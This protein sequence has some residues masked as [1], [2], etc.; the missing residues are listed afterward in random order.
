MSDNHCTINVLKHDLTLLHVHTQSRNAICTGISCQ[1]SSHYI[2]ITTKLIVICFCAV[3]Y[4]Y[5]LL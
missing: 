2:I 3:V 4:C 1:L 5:V